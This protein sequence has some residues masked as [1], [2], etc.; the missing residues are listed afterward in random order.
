MHNIT[1]AL[2]ELRSLK[3]KCDHMGYCPHIQIADVEKYVNPA[4]R[5]LE[6]EEKNLK[7]GD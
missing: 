7:K 5:F 6:K 3:N 2:R 1:R 4:I